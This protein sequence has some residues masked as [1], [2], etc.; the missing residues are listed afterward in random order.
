MGIG[1]LELI[2]IAGA[3]I[4]F[5]GPKKIPELAKSIKKSKEI[6]K[7]DENTDEVKSIEEKEKQ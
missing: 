6:L 5:L 1:L 7:E 3:I 4:L 2:L